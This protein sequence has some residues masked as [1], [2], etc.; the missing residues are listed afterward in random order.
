MQDVP[1]FSSRFSSVL[2]S[3]FALAIL[4]FIVIILTLARSNNFVCIFLYLQRASLV[5]LLIFPFLVSFVLLFWFFP[6]LLLPFSFSYFS[7]FHLSLL[8]SSHILV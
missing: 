3:V 8:L 1:S 7:L 4:I 5:G 2:L 6:F